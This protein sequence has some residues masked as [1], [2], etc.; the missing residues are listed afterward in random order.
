MHYERSP[1]YHGQVLA[2]LLECRHALGCDPFS[3]RSTPRSRAW[4]GR[5]P[6]RAS[7]RRALSLQRCRADDGLCARRLRRSLSARDRRHAPRAVRFS[8]PAIWLGAARRAISLSTAAASRPTICPRMGTATCI[9]RVIV[10]GKRLIVDQGVYEYVAGERRQR[11]RS[12]ASHN[13]L[14]F[15]GRIRPILRRLPLRPRP[16][17]EVLELRGTGTGLTRGQP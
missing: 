9:V 15:E 13:T 11:A 5:L 10:A 1:S 14:C 12:A 8:V 2:D 17:V 6:T 3:G 16:N 7:R 4:C